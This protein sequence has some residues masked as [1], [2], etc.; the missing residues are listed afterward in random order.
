MPFPTKKRKAANLRWIARKK[1]A[2]D[3]AQ[4]QI[5]FSEPLADPDRCEIL[6]EMD[7]PNERIEGKLS[8]VVIIIRNIYSSYN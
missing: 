5:R 7:Q 1:K 6:G 3:S 2:V 8:V 4:D